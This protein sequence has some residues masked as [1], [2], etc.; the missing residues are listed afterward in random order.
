MHQK[1]RKILIFTLLVLSLMPIALFILHY[2]GIYGTLKQYH[3]HGLGVCWLGSYV[4]ANLCAPGFMQ[5]A[6]SKDE[7]E[8]SGPRE[9]M[10]LYMS[11]MMITFVVLMVISF[12]LSCV[13]WLMYFLDA[14]FDSLKE[15]LLG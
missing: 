13:G 10:T 14:F 8:S 4:L 5:G 15:R 3:V 1:K 2:P 11:V 9:I 7:Y 12:A 6:T